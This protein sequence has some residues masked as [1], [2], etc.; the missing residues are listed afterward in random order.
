MKILLELAYI[1]TGFAGFQVQ[2]G[3]ITVQSALQD[4]I[5]ATYGQR[6]PVKG[7]S[8]TDAGVHALQY[9]AAFDT[10]KAIP[11]E[12]IPFAL[13]S[14]LDPRIS[15]KSARIVPDDFHVRHDVLWKEYEYVIRNSLIPDPFMLGRC[16]RP[17]RIIDD[18]GFSR[19]EAACPH[20]VGRHDFAGFMSAGATIADTTR[21]IF[22]L[23]VIR[24]GEYIRIRVSAD[25]FLYNMV[26]IIAGTLMDTANGRFEPDE[27]PA[28]IASC[29]RGRAGFTAPPEGL[30]LRRVELNE[31]V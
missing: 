26:R 6:Y 5:E 14:R 1:G 27:M 21:E 15:V 16:A 7:C 28:I 23:S 3:K 31:N 9:F 11:A 17:P 25:G 24:D 22:A 29:D 19:M 10:D 8:R 2:P 30:Y 12:R 18:V 13:N 4:A 20:F